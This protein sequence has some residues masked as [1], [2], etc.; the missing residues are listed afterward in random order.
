MAPHR[1][2]RFV[3]SFPSSADGKP[4]EKVSQRRAGLDLYGCPHP[5]EIQEAV[6]SFQNRELAQS[7][8]APPL[9]GQPV[10]TSAD[11]L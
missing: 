11:D 4:S 1:H 8:F 2:H 5:A 7:P 9:T 6:V 10:F 3:V